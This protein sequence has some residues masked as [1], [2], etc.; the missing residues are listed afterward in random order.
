[1]KSIILRFRDLVTEEGGTISDHKHLIKTTG[2]VWWGWWMKQYEEP[3][4]ELFKHMAEVIEREDYYKAY[5]FDSGEMK[6]FRTNIIKV[7]SAP[8]ATR[9]PPPDYI[10]APTYYHRGAYPAWF[11]LSKIEEV[12]ISGLTINVLDFPTLPESEYE[13]AMRNDNFK[14]LKES[15]KVEDLKQLRSTDV[16]MWEVEI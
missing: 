15:S 1:M 12:E 16:T 9:V 8:M 4:F 10:K 11:L 7:L 5:L 6:I 3:P 13:K 2:D 14:N